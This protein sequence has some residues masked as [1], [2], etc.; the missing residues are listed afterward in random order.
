[1]YV[2]EGSPD[3]EERTEVIYGV[4]NIIESTLRLLSTSKASL[5]NC[6]DSNG[7]SMLLI[8]GHPIRNVHYDMK[9]RGVKIRTI[10]EITSKNLPYCIELMNLAEVR[11][12]DDIKGNFGILDGTYYRASAKSTASSPPPLL[13][14]CTIRAFIE[15]QQYFFDTLWKK[16]MPAKRRINEI[17][18]GLE[19]EFIETISD[20]EEIQHRGYE[21]IKSANREILIM[22]S[23]SNAFR[24]QA[25]VGLLDV[26]EQIV[27]VSSYTHGINIRI[28]TPTDNRINDI[29]QRIDVLNKVYLNKQEQEAQKGHEDLVQ[30]RFIEKSFQST[31]SILVVDK[32]YSFVVELKDDS[33]ET[34][35][36]A[37]GFATYS[38]SKS[39]VFSF[40]SI[41][42]SFW[43]QVELYEKVK[44]HDTLQKDF[45][46]IA[47]HELRTPIQPILILSESLKSKVIDNE[48]N[49]MADII[50]RNAHRLQQLSE[51]ILDIAKIETQTLKVNKTQFDLN[52]LIRKV[53]ADQQKHIFGENNVVI[54]TKLGNNTL[55]V[56]ADKV[57]ITQ[58]INNLI[59]NAIRF[60]VKGTI[61]VITETTDGVENRSEKERA[62][63][64]SSYIAAVYVKDTGLGIDPEIFPRI[65][66]K[67]VT[68]SS[69][70]TGLG[71]YIS[72]KIVEAHGGK[73]WA[74]NNPNGQKGA[75]FAFNLPL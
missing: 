61:S 46:N 25:N 63:Q 30:L 58:V 7:P 57:R 54:E 43:K 37:I 44:L 50:H 56:Q 8:P 24:R 31:V 9:D 51:D 29:I 22:F 55:Y 13:V 72:K 40:V 19:S 73:I 17:E 49:R 18:Q 45:V 11:H 15:Q 1:M 33:K 36:D 47:A 21:L 32:K 4:E 10:T 62:C 16:A 59:N 39:T 12:L 52:D 69:D 66:E 38:N 75:T 53:V 34:S 27:N 5:D 26:L 2:L 64:N 74:R 60:T 71:L 41:F 14:S 35:Y 6:I 3:I 48:G 70:G 20:P 28:L 42:E 68:K 65:F 23:S 67:F